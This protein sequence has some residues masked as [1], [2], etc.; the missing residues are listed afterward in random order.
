MYFLDIPMSIGG[1][2]IDRG[3]PCKARV[4]IRNLQVVLG[5]DVGLEIRFIDEACLDDLGGI[6]ET[7]D[8]NRMLTFATNGSGVGDPCAW[9]HI[10][11]H[12]A[13]R[14]QGLPPQ[15]A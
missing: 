8:W 11:A 6:T 15:R 9:H 7:G 5:P 4:A 2:R 3:C 1:R 14:W 13:P 10:A 12:H